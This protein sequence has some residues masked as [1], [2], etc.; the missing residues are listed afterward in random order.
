[1]A[2]AHA[3]AHCDRPPVDDFFLTLREAEVL[4]LNPRTVRRSASTS[5][6]ASSRAGSSGADDDSVSTPKMAAAAGSGGALQAARA[7]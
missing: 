2:G 7:S 4:R 1:V 3:K 6:E 5:T